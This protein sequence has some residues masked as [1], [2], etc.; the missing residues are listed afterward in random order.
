VHQDDPDHNTN[1]DTES[2]IPTDLESF[3]SRRSSVSSMTSAGTQ[4]LIDLLLNHDNLH[5]LYEEA[6]KRVNA[7][8]FERHLRRFLRAYG[9]HL[10][11][12]AQNEVQIRASDFVR[13]YAWRAAREI[14]LAMLKTMESRMY[15]A[16]SQQAKG[17]ERLN[18]W[19]SSTQ[20]SQA[21]NKE[22]LSVDSESDNSD[23][24][25]TLRDDSRLQALG[26]V[27][28]FL[29]SAQAF[30]TLYQSLRSWLK[31]AD[32]D[33]AGE[34]RP[35]EV[36]AGEIT[37]QLMHNEDMPTNYED[38]MTIWSSWWLWLMS[39]YSPPQAGFQR[40]SYI[41]V[42]TLYTLY[43]TRGFNVL[44]GLWGTFISRCQRAVVRWT[45][46]IPAEAR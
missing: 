43:I 15:Q 16:S 28:D 2:T 11:N 34:N 12:E 39:I 31:L 30:T 3:S 42:S 10:K 6:T 40:I 4:E 27:R 13:Q 23:E 32:R 29:T 44:L 36:Q 24:G 8:K 17:R 33:V 26:E 46:K 9:D 38:K 20:K 18:L 45:R 14:K 1:T 41:C 21:T 35:L 7:E 37:Q 25:D 5:P 22:D 19:L